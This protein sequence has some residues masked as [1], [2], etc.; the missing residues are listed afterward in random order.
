MNAETQ[1]QQYYPRLVLE[2]S[3]EVMEF[4]LE[5]YELADFYP[6]N[7]LTRKDESGKKHFLIKSVEGEPVETVTIAP[8]RSNLAKGF[9]LLAIL[10]ATWFAVRFLL[11]LFLT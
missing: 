4:D 3:G 10:G 5:K 7:V 8:A 6:G 1:T 2:E 11:S 9:L